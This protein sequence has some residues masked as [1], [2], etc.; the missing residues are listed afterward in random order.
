MVWF[1]YFSVSTLSFSEMDLTMEG[2]S[3]ADNAPIRKDGIFDIV[4][5]AL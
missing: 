4:R 2:N 5:A 3:V 1:M